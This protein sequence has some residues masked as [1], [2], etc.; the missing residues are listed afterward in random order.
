MTRKGSRIKGN[1]F[2]Q[3]AWFSLS[4]G[5]AKDQLMIAKVNIKTIFDW[6]L[7][8]SLV[9]K[10]RISY[11]RSFHVVNTPLDQD[12]RRLETRYFLFDIKVLRCGWSLLLTLHNLTLNFCVKV[13]MGYKWNTEKVNTRRNWFVFLFFV[14]VSPLFEEW[15]A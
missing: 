9:K 3:L 7:M 1:L 10:E 12:T 13:R 4:P 11:C 2:I 5:T 15:S 6:I 8:N 14:S